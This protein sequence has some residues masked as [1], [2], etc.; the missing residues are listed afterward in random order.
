MMLALKVGK[1]LGK[2]GV[3]AKI[4]VLA[5]LPTLIASPQTP[6]KFRSALWLSDF[7]PFMKPKTSKPSWHFGVLNRLTEKPLKRNWLTCLA[8]LTTLSLRLVF[9]SSKLKA[10]RQI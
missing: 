7:L 4:V 8:E 10:K 9:C 2:K 1:L 3:M 6:M 5:L